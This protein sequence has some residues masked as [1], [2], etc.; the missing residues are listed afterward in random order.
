MSLRSLWSYLKKLSQEL[1]LQAEY[2][3]EWASALMNAKFPI[4]EPPVEWE[5]AAIQKFNRL[6]IEPVKALRTLQIESKLSITEKPESLIIFENEANQLAEMDDIICTLAKIGKLDVTGKMPEG[7]LLKSLP[8]T[9]ISSSGMVVVLKLDIAAA[10]AEKNNQLI[11]ELAEL[12]AQIL[13]SEKLLR[14][15]FGKKAPA[16]VV[17]KEKQKLAGLKSAAEKI[18]IQLG[19]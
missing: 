7:D 1:N 14:S 9:T 10:A 6:V 13:R 18:Q 5:E 8:T 15:D 16:A 17:D 12:E 3:Q 11:K 19:Q 2:D 4:P